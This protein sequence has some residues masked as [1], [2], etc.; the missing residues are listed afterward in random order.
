MTLEI[1][2]PISQLLRGQK[3]LPDSLRQ[4]SV[5]LRFDPTTPARASLLADFYRIQL[6]PELKESRLSEAEFYRADLYQ[7]SRTSGAQRK[8]CATCGQVMTPATIQ[9]WKCVNRKCQQHGRLVHSGP[10]RGVVD[11]RCDSRWVVSRET[12]PVI[13]N[14]CTADIHGVPLTNEIVKVKAALLVLDRRYDEIVLAAV[15]RTAGIIC[16]QYGWKL[17]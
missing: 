8:Q 1:L 10:V 13:L 3:L 7:P 15:Y 16:D 17:L 2:T 11:V 6:T 9:Y 4:N 14:G 12:I 5:L